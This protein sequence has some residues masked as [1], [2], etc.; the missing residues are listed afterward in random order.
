[1]I[2][3]ALVGFG[4]AGEHLHAPYITHP[5][6]QLVAVQ[7]SRPEAVAA[8]Y[9]DV[10]VYPSLEQLLASE[11]ID[12]V[13]IATPN[14]EHYPL[15]K[16]ALLA[17]CHVL[18]EKPFTVT[19]TEAEQLT[20]LARQQNRLLTVYH[21][22]R[23]TKDFR[24]LR[25][26]VQDGELG[27][28]QTFEAHYDRYRPTVRARWR[29]QDVP[30]AGLLYDLGSHLID[31][32]LILFGERPDRVFCDQ[33]I[34]RPDGP[35]EDYTHLIL[36]F[37]TRRAV[38]HIGSLVPASGPSLAVHGT[39]AS[40]FVDHVD[41]KEETYM[42]GR[43]EQPLEE[44]PFL[45]SGFKN[46]YLDLAAALRNEAPLAVTTEQALLVM[47]IIDCAQKSVKEGKWIEVE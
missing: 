6:Y 46:Y 14:A 24:T 32:A 36:A 41:T 43:P 11:T 35:V 40:Y 22:R 34:Q 2:R 37:G 29:E 20:D 13:V 28:V 3:T 39:K 5:D 15:A 8:R 31:Q 4:L 23:Y 38:L 47:K 30:G 21:N 17:G 26:L 18:V 42:W 12:L 19:L 44:R 10:P 25:Q 27:I 1:M 16:T 9:P 7:S 45:E 33:T